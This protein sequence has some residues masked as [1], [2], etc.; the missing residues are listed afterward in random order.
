MPPASAEYW[1][2]LIPSCATPLPQCSGTRGGCPLLLLLLLLEG[3][4]CRPA[5]AWDA[6]GELGEV[7][8][9]ELV[10]VGR[11]SR[12]DVPLQ[13]HPLR[14]KGRVVLGRGPRRGAGGGGIPEVLS[15]TRVR[16]RGE[17]RGGEVTTTRTKQGP[18][19]A[20]YKPRDSTL[21][22]PRMTSRAS[23]GAMSPWSTALWAAPTYVRK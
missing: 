11:H 4:L 1:L 5:H 15:S 22:A 10:G 14:G 8:P 13:V 16:E 21:H 12:I 18:I 2:G 7:E 23:A 19:Q 9:P 20:P 6:R 3:G 17:G